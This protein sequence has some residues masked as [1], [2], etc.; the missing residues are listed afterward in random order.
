M[1]FDS[2]TEFQEILRRGR[3]L[4]R[5]KDRRAVQMLAAS[6]AVIL[7]ALV[8]SIQMLSRN[9]GTGMA[10]SVFGAFLLPV[11]AGGYVLTAVIACFAGVVVTLLCIRYRQR[12]EQGSTEQEY[13][14]DTMISDDLI[15]AV[16]GGQHE[17]RK[18]ETKEE[19]T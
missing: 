4:R 16:A 11:E 17:D 18:E 12:K 1:R 3:M 15:A 14:H 8:L 5:E 10:Q 19:E 9:E 2:E 7:V 6:S 13:S